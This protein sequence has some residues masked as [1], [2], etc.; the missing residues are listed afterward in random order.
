MKRTRTIWFSL[1]ALFA[2][3]AMAAVP[4]YAQQKKPNILVIWG[5]DIGHDNISAYNRG[6]LDYNTPNI[7]RIAKEGALFT[8]HYAQQSCTAGRAAFALGQNPFRT[9]LLTIGMPARRM[10]CARKTPPSPSC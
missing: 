1:L 10:A 9:G 5:D 3:V 6:M 7:D 2:T 8:D 4:A